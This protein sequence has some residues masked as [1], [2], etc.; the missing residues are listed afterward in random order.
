MRIL[1]DADTTLLADWPAPAKGMTA[2]FISDDGTRVAVG[3]KAGHVEVR[4]L[5]DGNV[6]ED[7][8]LADAAAAHRVALANDNIHLA[9]AMPNGPLKLIDLKTRAVRDIRLYGRNAVVEQLQFSPHGRLLATVERSDFKVLCVYDIEQ[10]ARIAA[11]SLGN[12]SDAKLFAL[13]DGHS[14]VTID[15]GGRIVVHPVFENPE[16]FMAY[17]AKE[18]PDQLTPAQKRLYFIN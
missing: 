8:T 14:F 9:A 18:F 2:A 6:L 1:R 7:L 4:A 16:D 5:P 10:G 3:D 17:L 13:A 11:I 12:Q 15:T